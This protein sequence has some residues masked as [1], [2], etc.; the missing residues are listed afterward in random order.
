MIQNFTNFCLQNHLNS[1]DT[2]WVCLNVAHQ[3]QA[4]KVFKQTKELNILNLARSLYKYLQRNSLKTLSTESISFVFF[5]SPFS[6]IN[7]GDRRKVL[8]SLHGENFPLTTRSVK[9]DHNDLFIR[10]NWPTRDYMENNWYCHSE[11]HHY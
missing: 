10:I 4:C 9:P 3:K 2:A 1:I 6:A 5:F 7:V 11:K 8:F